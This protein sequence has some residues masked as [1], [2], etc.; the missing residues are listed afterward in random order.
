[1]NID[2]NIIETLKIIPLFLDFTADQLGRLSQITEVIE[3]DCRRRSSS[4]R[5]TT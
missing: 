1:M 2:L 4:G 3:L 5:S